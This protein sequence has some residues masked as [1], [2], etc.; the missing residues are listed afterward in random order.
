MTSTNPKGVQT[1]HQHDNRGREAEKTIKNPQGQ[2]LHREIHEYDPSGNTTQSTQEIYQGTTFSHS[3]V[4]QWT[5]GPLNRIEKVV[6]S[7]QKE[8]LYSYDARGRL[9]TITKPNKTQIHHD[10]DELGRL[11]RFYSDDIDYHYTYDKNDRL[12]TVYDTFSQTTTARTYDDYGNLIE[13]TLANG[14]T[15][16]NDYDTR[17]R[18]TR[19][20]L[21]DNSEITY[22][23][24][25]NDL[26]QVQRKGKSYTYAER[27]LEG[28]PTRI[29]LP[30][31]I[32]TI[33]I[34]RDPLSRWKEMTAPVY[35]SHF[36]S[37][38]YDSVGNLCSYSYTDSLGEQSAAYTY[39]DLR[40]LLSDQDHTYDHDSLNNRLRKDEHP[41]TV[42]D[43]CQIT[44]DGEQ[45]YIYDLNGNLITDGT[46]T[47]AYDSLDR[48]I[49]VK[50]EYLTLRFTYDPFHRRMIN[51]LDHGFGFYHSHFLWDGDNEIGATHSLFGEKI[52]ELRILGEGL[53][54]EI[55]AA[56]FIELHGTPYVPI[57]DHRGNVVTLIRLSTGKA[58][59]TYRYTAFG[60]ELTKGTLSP[61]RF[62]SKRVDSETGFVYF[63]RRYY[64]P[65]LG[66]WITPDPQGFQDGPNLYAYLHNCPLS[67]CDPYGLFGIGQCFGAVSR[68]AFRGLEWT[69][70]NL[71]PIPYVQNFTESVGR[72]GAGGEFRGASR[73]RSNINEIITIPGTVIPG[74]LYT[75]GNGMMAKRANAIKHTESTSQKNGGVQIDLLYHATNGLV[76]D[77]IC[78]GFSKL[79][80]PNDY[81]RMCANYYKAHLREDPNCR[82]TSSV[83]SRGGIQI[84]N[85]GRLLNP[86]QRKHI[87][88]LSYGSATL[89]PDD[90]FKSAKNNISMLD[91]VTMTNPIAYFMGLIGKQFDVIFLSPASCN[92]L[93]EHGLLEETYL[94]EITR[95]GNDFKE[96]Y[97]NN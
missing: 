16:K 15:L 7:H 96:L 47:Y 77:L 6:E 94:S 5:Y 21:P 97:F 88:V 29:D 70:A 92:P 14:F 80:I 81:N 45:D 25:G 31:D 34:Q 33:A 58:A 12:L 48:L 84:M 65:H 57:H 82:F 18:R 74:H 2:L 37:D 27:D 51:K 52:S 30:N 35:Q 75:H 13:E 10:Y 41:C 95:R 62:S 67:D 73:L 63:G 49:Q 11:I 90:Y 8:T 83:H 23:Y 50:R 64:S 68:M 1:I 42:N 9:Q 38:A 55:G 54:A 26:Y 22:S 39:D 20:T 91:L 53:G 71:L 69:G 87:D 76:S 17:G 40:Q 89:I 46:T 78:C 36:P 24:Q 4:N 3:L 86:E 56:T 19:L 28:A 59:Q 43:L 60:E 79:G 93:K 72:W 44:N 32:G 85:T 61:W 66:R